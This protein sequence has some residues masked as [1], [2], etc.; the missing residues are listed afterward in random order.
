MSHVH[1]RL[2]IVASSLAQSAGQL[3]STRS[4]TSMHPPQFH[5]Y[6]KWIKNHRGNEVGKEKKRKMQKKEK[7]KDKNK[8]QKKQ[9]QRIRKRR[10]KK[11]KE[12]R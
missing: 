7:K 2:R 1:M 6:V 4:A 3:L 5:L 9:E 10:R 12:K 8:K 11:T